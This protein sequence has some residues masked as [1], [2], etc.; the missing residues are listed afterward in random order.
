MSTIPQSSTHFTSSSASDL[1]GATSPVPQPS[2][3][4]SRTRFDA[5]QLQSHLLSVLT[6]RLRNA[7]WDK[8]DKDK[9]RSLSRSIAE[10]VKTKMLGE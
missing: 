4:T 9:N 7:T 10:F 6:S 1:V 3:S 5:A 2:A 8:S